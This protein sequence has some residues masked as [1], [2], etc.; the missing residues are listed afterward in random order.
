MLPSPL[1]LSDFVFTVKVSAYSGLKEHSL[2]LIS[3]I[4]EYNT[5]IERI[6]WINPHLFIYHLTQL[7][8]GQR[9]DI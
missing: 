7:L 8:S 9:N 5:Q 3:Y 2:Y 6:L 4:C 1:R